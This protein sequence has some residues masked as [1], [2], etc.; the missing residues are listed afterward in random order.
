MEVSFL[1]CGDLDVVC[2]HHVS[3]LWQ[4]SFQTVAVELQDL[5]VVVS[6]RVGSR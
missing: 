3:H 5:Q 2:A 1:E 6:V 4:L